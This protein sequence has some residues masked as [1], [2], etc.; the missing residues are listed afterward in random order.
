MRNPIV[1]D[2]AIP[3]GSHLQNEP[4]ITSLINKSTP[5]FRYLSIKN[6]LLGFYLRLETVIPHTLTPF[7]LLKRLTEKGCKILINI[8]NK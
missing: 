5:C 6:I 4:A 7:P 3:F 1:D 8:I 2:L